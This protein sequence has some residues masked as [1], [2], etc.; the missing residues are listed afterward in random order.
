MDLNPKLTLLLL[1]FDELS[2]THTCFAAVNARAVKSV[3]AQSFNVALIFSAAKPIRVE[4]G[5]PV[6]RRNLA[7]KVEQAFL[8]D[9][10]LF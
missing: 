6:N 3:P 10:R 1:R 4:R 7:A 8:M 9:Q 5:P 2:H